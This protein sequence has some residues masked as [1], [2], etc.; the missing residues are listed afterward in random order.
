MAREDNYNLG[1]YRMQVAE[2]ETRPSCAGSSIAAGRSIM[3]LGRGKTAPLP[4]AAVI[5]ADPGIILAAVTPVPD[6]VEYQFAGLFRGSGWNWLTACRNPESTVKRDR[7]RG[8]VSL[9]DYRDEV[10]MATIRLLQFGGPFPVFTVTA[11]PCGKIHLS[12][13]L[14]R[15]PA[16]RTFHPVVKALNEVFIPLIK[17]QF[18]E[19]VDFWLPPEGF[20]Y[21]IAVVAMKKAFPV[22]PRGDDGGV[23]VSAPIHVHQMGDRGGCDINARDWKDVMWAFPPAWTPAR[24]VTTSNIRHRLSGFRFAGVGTGLQIGLDAT[25]AAPETHREMGPQDR[26]GRGCDPKVTDNGHNLGLP[27]SGKPICEIEKAR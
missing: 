8:E 4:V 11:S 12:F 25:Q 2:Q 18:P 21:R 20:S 19:I 27:G 14:Y 9:S 5:G 22:T 13:H 10:P 24:D 3:P 16:G 6:P 26:D 17:P 1:I 7:H 15:A 23:V